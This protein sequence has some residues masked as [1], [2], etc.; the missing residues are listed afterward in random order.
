MR[1]VKQSSKQQRAG[2]QNENI[3]R[4]VW[5]RSPRLRGIARW[6]G[7]P[8][9]RDASNLLGRR[10]PH[11]GAGQPRASRSTCSVNSALSALGSGAGPAAHRPKK[12]GRLMVLLWRRMGGRDKTASEAAGRRCRH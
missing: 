1:N 10:C 4:G 12:D 5:I 9:P 6:R 2:V 7:Y 3:N 8:G 11:A